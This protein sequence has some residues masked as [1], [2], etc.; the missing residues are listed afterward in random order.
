MS[1]GNL[2][3]GQARGS[4]GDVTFTHIDGVQVARAR[5]RSPRNPRVPSQ[6]LQRIVLN[7]ASKAYSLMQAIVDHSF[8]GVAGRARNQ[9]RF[10]TI[11]AAALRDKLADVIADPTEQQALASLATSYSFK[12]DFYPQL[13]PYVISEGTLPRQIVDCVSASNP[14]F[15]LRFPVNV[16]LPQSYEDVCRALDIQPG[17]QLTFIGLGH[18]YG[19]VENYDQ[20][21]S[22]AFARVIME[23]ADGDMT[24]NFLGDDDQPN[25][26]NPKNQG[27][28][29]F[30]LSSD[31]EGNY[32]EF[33]FS[34][35]TN[36]ESDIKPSMVGAAVILSRYESGRWRRSPQS[37][38]LAKFGD[39]LPA[40]DTATFGAAYASYLLGDSSN[41]YLNGS[42]VGAAAHAAPV[43][44]ATGVQV[45]A[46]SVTIGQGSVELMEN[47]NVLR[48]SGTNLSSSNVRVYDPST[49]TNYTPSSSSDTLIEFEDVF[50]G[51]D[52]VIV[53]INGELWCALA[54]TEP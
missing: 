13:N 30:S 29:Y 3:L 7:S 5:N 38:V 44:P 11:N 31:A 2:F 51:G 40:L 8:E 43:Q 24:A 10:M 45:M 47:S 4:V 23:P 32:L 14:R 9:Q 50:S 27:E 49:D 18:Q 46:G 1:K 42:P 20:T 21:E 53:E 34:S 15:M 19:D 26:P 39:A 25:N 41:L 48:I 16:E 22:F 17:D 36:T 35:M 12:G 28:V 6:M 33:R 37:I 54:I 52:S